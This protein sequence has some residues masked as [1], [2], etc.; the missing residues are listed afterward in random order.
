MA[1]RYFPTVSGADDTSADD[2]T[3]VKWELDENLVR[4]VVLFRVDQ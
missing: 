3:E 4:C 1:H 2:A